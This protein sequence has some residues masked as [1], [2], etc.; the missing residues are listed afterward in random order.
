MHRPRRRQRR[1]RRTSPGPLL[2]YVQPQGLWHQ[3][4]PDAVIRLRHQTGIA[5]KYTCCCWTWSLLLAENSLY[6]AQ[7]C[8][9][10]LQHSKGN[11]AQAVSSRIA[12]HLSCAYGTHIPDSDSDTGQDSPAQSEAVHALCQSGTGATPR[13]AIHLCR[14]PVMPAGLEPAALKMTAAG[15][16][17]LCL[18]VHKR[19]ALSHSAAIASNSCQVVQSYH[20]A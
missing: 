9:D 6:I 16:K 1:L 5:S 15:G 2:K 8:C 11:A 10:G 14:E 19:N 18:P 4:T 20:T 17:C 7:L 12:V 13:T 3:D